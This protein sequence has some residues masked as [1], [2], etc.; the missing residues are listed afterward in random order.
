MINGLHPPET[1]DVLCVGLTELRQR[2]PV[3]PVLV[4]AGERPIISWL[5]NARVAALV[6]ER[7]GSQTTAGDLRMA[8]L[9]EEARLLQQPG[10]TTDEPERLR[11]ILLSIVGQV[12]GNARARAGQEAT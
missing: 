1:V 12:R 2:L 7:L 6:L 10:E 9:P 11:E 3:T 4:V 8:L 5:F